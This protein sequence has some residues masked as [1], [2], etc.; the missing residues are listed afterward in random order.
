[1]THTLKLTLALL[2]ALTLVACGGAGEPTLDTSSEETMEESL[3]K[4]TADMSEEEHQ[5]FGNALGTVFMMGALQHMESGKSEEEILE[6]VNDSVHGK[7]ADEIKEMAA[8]MEE[9]MQRQL[10]QMQ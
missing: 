9:D 5:A 7:T 2:L 3:E 10:Q 4:M 8:G 1:M 6:A